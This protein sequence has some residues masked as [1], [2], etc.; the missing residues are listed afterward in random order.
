MPVEECASD[1]LWLK[2]FPK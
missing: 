1:A 2:R